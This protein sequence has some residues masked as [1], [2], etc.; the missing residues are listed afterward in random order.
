MLLILV[1]FSC[2][3]AFLKIAMEQANMFNKLV[4]VGLGVGYAV[5]V[6]LT[7]G[8]ALKMIPS[9]GVTLPLVSSGGSSIL[10]TLFVFAIMQGLAIVGTKVKRNVTRRIPTEGLV[11]EQRQTERIRQLERTGEI[12][13]VGKKKK[14]IK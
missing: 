2:F 12:G 3:I 9:T 7:I 4:C 8:G 14:K 11:N 10:S 5:Q 13:K 6:F 1:C